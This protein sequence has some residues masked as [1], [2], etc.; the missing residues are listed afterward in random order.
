MRLA[1]F[2]TYGS[3]GGWQWEALVRAAHN[4]MEQVRDFG[5]LEVCVSCGCLSRSFPRDRKPVA[6]VRH[7]ELPYQR[8]EPYGHTMDLTPSFPSLAFRKPAEAPRHLPGAR[9]DSL[10]GPRSIF[11]CLPKISATREHPHKSSRFHPKH[12]EGNK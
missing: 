3:L 6:L 4:A 2:P 9:K 8:I 12:K 10:D 5:S 1:F 7:Q 11:P